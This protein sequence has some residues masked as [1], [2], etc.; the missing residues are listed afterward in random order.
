MI[1][2]KKLKN[3]IY[4]TKLPKDITKEIS[5]WKKNC[6]KTKRH[7]LGYLKEHENVGF[8]GNDYQISVPS[9][10]VENSFWFPYT[11]K[12]AAKAFGGY[13]RDYFLRKWNNHFDG[14]DV[15]I[16]YA[17]KN[18]FNPTHDHAG[19]V[20]GVIY[21]NNK[22]NT[23]F[24]DDNF[25]FCGKKGDMIMFPAKTRHGV[26]RQKTEYERITFAFNLEKRTYETERPA[27]SK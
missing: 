7:P 1:S 8:F 12:A 6:D 13:H 9:H 20:S 4:Y 18:C 15:W 24:P 2:I 26:R 21:F 17:K 10:L 14:Y 11:L 25:K 5:S 22:E 23:V 27:I 16:N 19:F 3:N